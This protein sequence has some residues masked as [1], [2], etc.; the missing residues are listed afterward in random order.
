MRKYNTLVIAVLVVV[1]AIMILGR[2]RN[3]D[4]WE[5]KRAPDFTLRDLAGNTVSLSDFG[6][7]VV[8]L[9]FWSAACP[10]CREEMPDMQTVFDELQEQG[11]EIVAVN[12]ND[13]PDVAERFLSDNGYTFTVVKDDGQVSSAYEVQFIPKTFIIDREGIVRH[14]SVGAIT[15]QE[16]RDLVLR[17]L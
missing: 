16:L 5:G 12:V 3:T 8:M 1:L 11:F 14:M 17:W 6:D 4:A 13:R 2:L 9:N 10:P 7:R 15:E